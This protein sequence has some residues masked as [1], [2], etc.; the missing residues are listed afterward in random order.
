MTDEYGPPPQI[1]ITENA[2]TSAIWRRWFF[3]LWRTVES[4]LNQTVSVKDFGA[5]GD[6]VTDDTAA[7]QA[8][9]DA[10]KALSYRTEGDVS[11]TTYNVAYSF[12]LLFP[13]GGYV[14]TSPID[15]TGIRL[16]HSRWY[17]DAR[18]AVI[19]LRCTG[20]TGFDLTDSR[21][22][23]WLGGTIIGEESTVC[24][25]GIQMGRRSDG[26]ASDS[27]HF[28]DLEV[29]GYFSLACI[30]NY[31]S[32]DT[33]F[34]HVALKN[35]YEVSDCYC[36]VQDGDHTFG[37]ES[38]YETPA[39]L[40]TAASFL[41]D[42]F[43]RLDARLDSGST[44][45]AVWMSRTSRHRY[46]NCYVVSYDL[47]GFLLYSNTRAIS[48]EYLYLDVHIE[49][50]E[51]DLNAATGVDHGI[52]FD[53][54]SSMAVS[55]NS[56]TFI[57]HYAHSQVSIFG[58]STNAT[59]VAL[60]NLDANIG[61]VARDVGQTIFDT[62][63]DYTVVGRLVTTDTTGQHN[64]NGIGGFRG[65]FFNND[66]ETLGRTDSGEFR[67]RDI[68]KDYYKNAISY[69]A[70]SGDKF[71][72]DVYDESGTLL[73]RIRYNSSAVS[74]YIGSSSDFAMTGA[75][76]YPTTTSAYQLGLASRYWEKGFID[77][78]YSGLTAGITAFATG[79]QGSATA[80]TSDINEISTCA[81]TG[82]SVKLPTAVAGRVVR[83]INNGAAACDVFPWASDDIGAGTNTAI[84]LAAGAGV[85]YAAY[86]TTDWR[87]V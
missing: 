4:N 22:C 11:N 69:M 27:H 87:A 85:T 59:S 5:V 25:T 73:Y 55:A 74:F 21:K 30:Y 13:P 14:I 8:A 77:E 61:D 84:S 3:G 31:A 71:D 6:G 58:H 39:S 35:G 66:A 51:G 76:F 16:A 45:A 12:S 56:V 60:I 86:S 37:I 43:V 26:R 75:A 80:L 46:D 67:N 68:V 52:Y 65:E 23:S 54:I 36:L 15:M 1:N 20:K 18:G 32:E 62:A 40:N 83:I 82:D 33:M 48:N 10:L 9:V 53:A 50:D 64:I 29:K 28:Q 44:G 19:F 38:D 2:A 72:Q 24:R 78:I 42:H 79:G 81:T 7:I 63:A 57:D 47:A 70:D 34:T 49:T 41:S 17:V